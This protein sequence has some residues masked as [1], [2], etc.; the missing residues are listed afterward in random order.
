MNR[1]FL[2]CIFFFLPAIVLAQDTTYEIQNDVLFQKITTIKKIAVSP[3]GAANDSLL[4][5][6][7]M[8]GKP[9]NYD[10]TTVYMQKFPLGF[11]FLNQDIFRGTLIDSAHAEGGM[12]EVRIDRSIV[13]M[14][15]LTNYYC[16]AGLILLPLVVLLWFFYERNNYKKNRNVPGRETFSILML[17]ITATALLSV[18]IGFVIFK[19]RGESPMF[20]SL[21]KTVS[22]V[23]LTLVLLGF[24][25]FAIMAVV[26][27]LLQ[28]KYKV[29]K[30]DA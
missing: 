15:T 28:N 8:Q 5:V 12:R 1:I 17:S 26:V 21:Q 16:L 25:Q 9:V 4:I 14:R 10:D 11:L 23:G 18:L 19:Q 27:Q 30:E 6:Q 24:V 20:V 2:I 3:L 13:H 29:K 22:L 7:A